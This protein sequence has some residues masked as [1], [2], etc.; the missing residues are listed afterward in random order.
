MNIAFLHRDIWPLHEGSSI[1]SWELFRRLQKHHSL[2]TLN[3][4]PFPRAKHA[5]GNIREAG[6]FLNRID[7]IFIIVDGPYYFFE[8]KFSFLPTLLGRNVPV[9]W[10]LNAPLEEA[11]QS[12]HLK[13]MRYPIDRI[14]RRI[15]SSLVTTCICVSDVLASYAKRNLLAKHY[16]VIPNGSDITYFRPTVPSGH[17]RSERKFRV[18]WAGSGQYRWQALDIISKAAAIMIKRDADVVFD[19]YTDMSWYP[20]PHL[21]NIRMH[22]TK[23]HSSL[24]AI[25]DGADVALCLY[26]DVT[27]QGFYNSPLKL[28]D[29][30]AAGVP[31]IA[32]DIGQMRT[33]LRETR[34]GFLTTND[35]HAIVRIIKQVKRNPLAAHRIGQRARQSVASFYNWD[36]M[37][38]DIERVIVRTVALGT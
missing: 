29:A 33:V 5:Y 16:E 18:V 11:L 24:R 26:H 6:T 10:L 17:S 31:V 37:A 27:G 13:K 14:L 25:F 15:S 30:M 1:Q 22:G 8:E 32:T 4:C 19:L 28:F 20:I 36:R 7:A 21:P 35:P 23:N 9:V 34:S 38:R 2:L 12:D 3:T